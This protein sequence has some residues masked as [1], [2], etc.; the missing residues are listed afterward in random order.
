MPDAETNQSIPPTEQP[1]ESRNVIETRSLSAWDGLVASAALFAM[2]V[3][4]FCV[5]A[6]TAKQE[7]RLRPLGM[8]V[9]TLILFLIL[10][11][12]ILGLWK[13]MSFGQH[14]GTLLIGIAIIFLASGVNARAKKSRRK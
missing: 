5:M 13:A 11:E 14:L 4:A 7:V 12:I 9:G 8:I 10:P 2:I 3:L 1:R 6:G